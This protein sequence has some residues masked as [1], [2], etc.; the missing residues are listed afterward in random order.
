MNLYVSVNLATGSCK[1]NGGGTFDQA[2]NIF[3]ASVSYGSDWVFD[4]STQ[5]EVCSDA[6]SNLIG[7]TV[8]NLKVVSSF[9]SLS[10]YL[11]LTN[12][13]FNSHSFIIINSLFS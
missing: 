1:F 12:S 9:Y 6:G 7:C 8:Q 5:I 13:G 11:D 10:G 4:A 2:I 3:P